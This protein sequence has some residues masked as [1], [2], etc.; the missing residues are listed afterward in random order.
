MRAVL[1]AVA[2]E[3]HASSVCTTTLYDL[4]EE[5]QN[6]FRTH[7]DALIVASV[8]HLLQSRRVTFLRPP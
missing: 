3:E 8:M 2:P 1:D 5:R 6:R 4:I 7:A